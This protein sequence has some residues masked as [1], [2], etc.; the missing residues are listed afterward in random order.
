[1]IRNFLF[2]IIF[3]TIQ[4]HGQDY[5]WP[6]GTGKQLTS[7]FGE[8]RDKHFHMGIDIRTNSSVGHPI[9]A[10]QDGYIH[11]IA[12]DFRGYGKVLYLKTNDYKIVVYGH[13]N[14]FTEQ[15]ENLLFEL[16][17]ENQSYL[18]NKYFTPEEY[19]VKRGEIIGF[20]GNSGGSTGPHLHFELR[21]GIEQPL[22]PMTNGFPITDNVPPNFLDLSII[23]LDK[24]TRINDSPMPQNYSPVQLSPSEYILKD[25]ISVAGIFGI[26][27][28]VIDKIQEATF[29]YQIEKMELLVDSI[30]AFSIH[31]DSLDF[32][33]R[34]YIATVFGQ[35]ISH[36]KHDDFQKLYRLE[37]YPKLTIHKGDKYGIIN[38]PDGIH[39]V[40]IVASDA[41]QNESTLIFYIRSII[42]S[43]KVKYKTFLNLNDYPIFNTELKVFN[44]E[45]IQLEKGAIFQLQTD[46]NSSDTI[47]AFI[48]SPNMVMTF[49][50]IKIDVD[51]YV[52]EMI[53]PYLFKDSKSCGFLIYSDEIQKYEFGFTPMLILPDSAQKI[54]SHDGLSSFETNNAIYD[55]T[56]I[57]ITEQTFKPHKDSV[58]YK[59]NIF[60]LHP[61]GIPFKNDIPI[62]LAINNDIDL[63]RCA[64]YT[65]NNKKSEWDFEKSNIDAINNFIT[66]KFSE[67][68]IF[69][70]L[71]DTLPPWF[72]DIYPENQQTYSKDILEQFI[73]TLNDDLSG[74]D[75]SEECLKVYLDGK[76]IWVAYQPVDK[77]ISYILRNALSIGEHNLLINIQDRSG[78]S[79]SKTIKFFVE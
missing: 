21:N 30:S 9:Y 63:K 38:L 51:K 48:E 10:V 33:E 42:P 8:F 35:P 58:T 41:A 78:N 52:S 36:P 77:E 60:E 44:P 55:T 28:Q 45:L 24:G 39:K 62:S 79:A 2:L 11:R 76:R 61:Y 13:L 67:A 29:S 47:R 34:E 56:L 3:I 43:K 59:S 6:T 15:L 40:E 71:E 75:L 1:M 65:F 32:S 17:N 70:I 68:N 19:S 4:I 53:N 49:P 66:A 14:E 74:I 54:I 37:H 22:N 5:V 31:Y 50:L 7:N 20:S 25:T 73:I 72:L 18:V 12:T 69:S 46:V 64:I 26:T 16:Q 23:P 57:W 27:T